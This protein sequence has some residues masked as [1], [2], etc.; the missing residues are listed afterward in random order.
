MA[1]LYEREVNGEVVERAFVPSADPARDARV[2][3][4]AGAGEDGWREGGSK[5]TPVTPSRPTKSGS[6]ADWVA[7]A[8]ANGAEQAEAEKATKD[9]LIAAYGQDDPEAE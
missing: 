4:Q 7:W 9:D 2:R 6:K 1:T 3:E 5:A 8:V